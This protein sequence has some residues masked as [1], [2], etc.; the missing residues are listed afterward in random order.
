MANAHV[1]G[2]TTPS[3]RQGHPPWYRTPTWNAYDCTPQSP[4]C[5]MQ[6]EDVQVFLAHCNKRMCR[7][8]CKLQGGFHAGASA[9]C[10]WVTHAVAC[11][12]RT[13]LTSNRAICRCLCTLQRGHSCR[14]LCTLQPGMCRRLCALHPADFQ[15]GDLQV[16]LHTANGGIC[17]GAFAHCNH[18]YVQ[19]PVHT[20]ARNSCRCLCTPHPADFQPDNLQVPVHTADG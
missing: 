16:P 2:P 11:A 10:D 19:V 3:D 8:L 1:H 5:I 12:H 6:P 17:A 4:P 9:R 20:A 18:K 7:C 14:C 13:R 15:P